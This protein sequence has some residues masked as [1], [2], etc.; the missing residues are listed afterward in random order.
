MSARPLTLALLTIAASALTSC[1]DVT[2]PTRTASPAPSTRA[3]LD[4]VDPTVCRT[5]TWN[6]S[7]GR[8]E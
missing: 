5:G 4:V 8:C 2:N 1:A 6:S 7:S 3:S